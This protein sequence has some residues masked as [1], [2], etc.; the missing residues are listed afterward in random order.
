[1]LNIFRWY[2]TIAFWSMNVLYTIAI[3]IPFCLL[4]PLNINIGRWFAIGWGKACVKICFLP[5]K[6][7]GKENIPTGPVI[8]A[9]NHTSMIDIHL[10]L[11]YLPKKFH[12]LMKEELFKIPLFG[13]A[14][15]ML[16]FYPLNR[17][18]PKRAMETMQAVIEHLKHGESVLIF[19]EGT[20]NPG[21]ELL[22]FKN[23]MAKLAVESQIPVL[24]FAVVGCNKVN[25][26]TKK[27]L[28]WHPLEI[29]IGTAITPPTAT[30]KLS[31]V[32]LTEQTR[33]A[34]QAL[35]Q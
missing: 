10:V 5:V 9:G 30:D 19:P 21:V 17:K 28:N 26:S 20:R 2:L 13:L 29:R 25:P 33:Q 7:L 8:L 24:P 1:M 4:T 22:P 15:K 16:G 12:F 27:L 35:K 14:V 31:I 32:A 18:N 6:V 11:G 34:I 23:G 3:F